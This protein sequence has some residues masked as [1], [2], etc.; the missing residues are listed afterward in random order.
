MFAL[1]EHLHMSVAQIMEMST[2]EYKGWIAYL[3]RKAK[4][5]KHRGHKTRN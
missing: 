3:N 1:A 4:K 2:L 5:E